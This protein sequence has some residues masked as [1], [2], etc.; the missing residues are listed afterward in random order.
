MTAAETIVSM[1]TSVAEIMMIQKLRWGLRLRMLGS[2]FY[3]ALEVAGLLLV[4]ALGVVQLAMG[5]RAPGLLFVAL[6]LVGVAASWWARRVSLRGATGSLPELI[7]LSLRRARRG[8]RMA[9]ANYFMTLATAATIL[10]LYLSSF[11]DRGAAYHDGARVSV[12]M[13]MLVIYAIGI[14]VYHAYS[15]RRVR[16][17]TGLRSQMAPP[18]RRMSRLPR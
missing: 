13:A 1:R 5:E 6:A 14:G 12:A 18:S 17:F 15:R 4:C 2:W 3:L 7:E 11:G 16:R 8:V 10:T 9:W